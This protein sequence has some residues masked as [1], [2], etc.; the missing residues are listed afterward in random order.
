MKKHTF[1]PV[2]MIADDDPKNRWHQIWEKTINYL[3]AG[4]C[5]IH[6]S[7]DTNE[8]EHFINNNTFDVIISDT[9]EMGKKFDEYKRTQDKSYLDELSLRLNNINDLSKSQQP[10]SIFVI[11]TSKEKELVFNQLKYDRFIPKPLNGNFNSDD[12]KVVSHLI[13]NEYLRTTAKQ[14]DTYKYNE[15]KKSLGNSF[16]EDREWFFENYDRLSE[17]YYPNTFVAVHEG[18][19]IASSTSQRKLREEV[20]NNNFTSKEVYIGHI[21]DVIEH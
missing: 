14:V 21:N 9:L 11:S 5:I 18:N 10:K 13:H 4:L 16:Y 8:L 20:K 6:N 19:I 1:Y 2:Y 12:D 3:H 17:E 7:Y 15:Y